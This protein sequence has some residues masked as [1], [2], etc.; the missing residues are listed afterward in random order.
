MFEQ[1]IAKQAWQGRR[2]ASGTVCRTG[3]FEHRL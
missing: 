1:L 3:A 2:P